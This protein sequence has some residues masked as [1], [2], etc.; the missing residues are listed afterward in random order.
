MSARLTKLQNELYS[1]FRDTISVEHLEEISVFLE[2]AYALGENESNQQ[3]LDFEYDRGYTEGY[4][5]G[6]ADTE[7][8]IEQ[9]EKLAYKRALKELTELAD[10][11]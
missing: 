1:G 2:E 4:R 9:L 11:I 7:F 6:T 8:N 3:E 5:S 10:K